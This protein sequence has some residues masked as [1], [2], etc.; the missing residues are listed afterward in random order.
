MS[1]LASR[2]AKNP[3]EKRFGRLATLIAVTG[4]RGRLWRD[5][6]LKRTVTSQSVIV[7]FAVFRASAARCTSAALYR[8]MRTQSAV[9]EG[10]VLPLPLIVFAAKPQLLGWIWATRDLTL[11]SIYAP[12]P[13]V[14]VAVS[15]QPVV[16]Y[17]AVSTR[18]AFVVAADQTA[19]TR[20]Y[21]VAL[22]Y[23]GMAC[24][25]RLNFR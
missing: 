1:R 12:K 7:S 13:N 19:A 17:L 18:K 11:S 10:S 4:F 15:E 23:Y 9:F 8:A 16:V 21:H 25:A 2:R 5:C 14:R 6:E 3:T 20:R 24:K 22:F